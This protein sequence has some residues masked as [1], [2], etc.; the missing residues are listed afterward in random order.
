MTRS[1]RL[2]ALRV[3]L[4]VIPASGA[5][6]TGEHAT[7]AMS[8]RLLERLTRQWE[9]GW[10]LADLGTGGGILVLAAKRLGAERVVGIDVD[11]KAISI[12]KANA[13][14]NK[15]DNVDFRLAD[16]RRWKP[17]HRID[18][19]TGNLYSELLIKILPKLKY[20]HWLI[21]SGVLRTEE[22]EFIRVLRQ[23][24]VEIVKVKRRGKWI[25]ALAN[26]SGALP[27]TP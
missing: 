10:S 17:A 26:S 21:L 24:K 11:P 5:F 9:N 27:A 20:S 22:N 8:L 23:N 2:N 13:R 25:A 7:T 16:L 19:V 6:G 14:L 4:L 12:A 3:P 1:G 18:V 15:I